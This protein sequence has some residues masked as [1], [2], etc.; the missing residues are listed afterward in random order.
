MISKRDWKKFVRQV[1]NVHIALGKNFG[2]FEHCKLSINE[3]QILSVDIYK[4]EIIC[5]SPYR[6]TQTVYRHPD[7]FRE[8]DP[9]IKKLKNS[10]RLELKAEGLSTIK[11]TIKT[12]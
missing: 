12:K 10:L 9:G 8:N 3:Q 5:E 1:Y 6:L 11:N 7:S 4:D 2:D